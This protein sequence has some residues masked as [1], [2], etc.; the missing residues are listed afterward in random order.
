MLSPRPLSLAATTPNR[1]PQ[2]HQIIK[3]GRGHHVLL[4][5]RPKR[6]F[7]TIE[8]RCGHRRREQEKANKP[9]I[10]YDCLTVFT[11]RVSPLRKTLVVQRPF[12]GDRQLSSSRVAPIK[13]RF[14]TRETWTKT[15]TCLLFSD[16]CARAKMVQN[17]WALALS[18]RSWHEERHELS[19]TQLNGCGSSALAHLLETWRPCL[20]SFLDA[21]GRGKN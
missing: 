14:T 17:G 13:T 5:A 4:R 15:T 11:P 19:L 10:N 1:G 8:V 6:P 21:G 7:S 12:R 3:L 20:F 2:N 9:R 18:R 16:V